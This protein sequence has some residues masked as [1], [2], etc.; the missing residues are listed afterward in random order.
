MQVQLIHERAKKPQKLYPDSVSY[1]L[2]PHTWEIL[3]KGQTAEIDLGIAIDVPKNNIG[4]VTIDD[5]YVDN[6]GIEL[7]GGPVFIEP[8]DH[9]PI[10][11]K[12]TNTTKKRVD[13]RINRP[14][15]RLVI[16][17]AIMENVEVVDELQPVKR[18]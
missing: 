7:V 16:V 13:L 5:R 4:I 17:P 15:A 11:L 14:I 1:E 8:V 6:A 9:E 12:I 3:S 2:Y 10:K 18:R